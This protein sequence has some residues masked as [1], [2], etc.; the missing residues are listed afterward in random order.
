MMGLFDYVLG[1]LH[2]PCR[3]S[4]VSFQNVGAG[5]E[6]PHFSSF[7]ACLFSIQVIQAIVALAAIEEKSESIYLAAMERQSNPF[8]SSCR[9]HFRDWWPTGCSIPRR[10]S[11]RKQQPPVFPDPSFL[12][13]SIRGNHQRFG[14]GCRSASDLGTDCWEKPVFL[15]SLP[16]GYLFCKKKWVHRPQTPFTV[17]NPLQ[18][19]VASTN[20]YSSNQPCWT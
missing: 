8:P 12:S 11:E 2:F 1:L 9:T 20:P 4:P 10:A 19:W 3:K 16:I 17:D 14:W 5:R 7:L 18:N 6:E 15:H 13:L